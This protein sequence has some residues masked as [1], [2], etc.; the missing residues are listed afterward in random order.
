MERRNIS[1]T[2]KRLFVR[3]GNGKDEKVAFTTDLSKNGLCIKTSYVFN[4]GTHLR[5]Q[6]TLPDN[7]VI[8]LAGEVRWAKQVPANLLRY[9]KKAGMGV[10]L[11]PI[12]DEYRR[13]FATLEQGVKGS[14]R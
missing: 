6:L 9:T 8:E 1:R 5:I 13:Y 3:F 12:T 10:L 14:D 11:R 2:G 7:K 4:P